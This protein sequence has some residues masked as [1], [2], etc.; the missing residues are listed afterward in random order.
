MAFELNTIA[1]L[2]EKNISIMA[3]LLQKME[4]LDAALADVQTDRATHE[5]DW[6]KKTAFLNQQKDN[7]KDEIRA[8]R[9]VS[10]KEV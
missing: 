9:T 2:D 5:A 10:V 7:V 1:P 3:D 4:A 8:L 6:N